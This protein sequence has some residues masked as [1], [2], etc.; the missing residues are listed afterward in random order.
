M[1]ELNVVWN[2]CIK[3]GV[4]HPSDE[5]WDNFSIVDKKLKEYEKLKE[6]VKRVEEILYSKTMDNLPKI[7]QC[8][9][10]LGYK[11]EEGKAMILSVGDTE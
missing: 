10:I 7:I 2:E 4:K 1:K 11:V 5:W 8:K 3:Q 9:H 6:K